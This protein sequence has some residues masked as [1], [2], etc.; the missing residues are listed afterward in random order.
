VGRDRVRE[1]SGIVDAVQRRQ[2]LRRHLLVQLHVLV[3][4]RQDRA[5]ERFGLGRLGG[6]A[7][8]RIQRAHEVLAGVV[9]RLDAGAVGAFDQ[10]LD[11]AVGQLQQLQDVGNTA[12]RVD[13]FGGGFILGSVL[14]G[15][16]HD[17]LARF[18]GGFQCLDGFGRPTKSGI[19]M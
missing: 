8:D 19:T 11:R 2:D 16:E 10:H 18:H 7:V 1:T 17:A 13:V 12:D 5:P 9:D 14:L 6:V 3:E 4:L 15:H